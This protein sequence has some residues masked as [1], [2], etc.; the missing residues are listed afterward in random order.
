MCAGI[1]SVK[2]RVLSASYGSFFFF[3]FSVLFRLA[4]VLLCVVTGTLLRRWKSSI[5]G[6]R[7]ELDTLLIAN[8]V[9]VSNKV[10]AKDFVSEELRNE[11]TAFWKKHN[12]PQAASAAGP[13]SNPKP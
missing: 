6:V 10:H 4:V 13:N 5:P 9:R 12:H 3:F 11:F 1:L 7:A 8:S 2:V